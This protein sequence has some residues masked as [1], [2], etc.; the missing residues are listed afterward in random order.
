MRAGESD[1][2]VS[3]VMRFEADAALA[4]VGVDQIL[5]R[6]GDGGEGPDGT[7]RGWWWLDGLR[8][9]LMLLVVLVL[10]RSGT[11]LAGKWTASS[12]T[13]KKSAN[14]TSHLANFMTEL[15]PVHAV[16]VLVLIL[17]WLLLL[18]LTTIAATSDVEGIA[19]EVHLA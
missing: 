7:A 13:G 17:V 19:E 12:S 6:D 15:G 2:A 16:I 3:Q 18:M 9:L 5:G 14:V 10:G 11:A 8:C 1:D 4:V